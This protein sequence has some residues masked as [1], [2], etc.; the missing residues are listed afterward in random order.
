MLQGERHSAK[1]CTECHVLYAAYNIEF[2]C[3]RYLKS[4]E[5]LLKTTLEQVKGH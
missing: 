1:K 5:C 2:C 3:L 4:I